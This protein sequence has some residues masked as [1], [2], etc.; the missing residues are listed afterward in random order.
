[1]KPSAI[2]TEAG[3][4]MANPEVSRRL[5]AH[6]DSV[7]RSAVSSALSRRRFVLEGL[8]AV[9]SGATSE[10]AKVAALIA[11]GKTSGVDLFT[12]KIEVD[13]ARSASE[14]RD[15]LERRLQALLTGT[16]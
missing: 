5:H 10:S 15:E 6:H 12:D 9:A 16:G 2:Y 11:L 13:D 8:E 14:V 1:M 3:R 7:E 4:V